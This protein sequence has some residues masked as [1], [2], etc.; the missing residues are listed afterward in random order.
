M[1]PVKYVYILRSLND[2]KQIYIGIANDLRRRL[3]QHNSGQSV[4]TAKFMPWD[5]MHYSAFVDEKK[6]HEFEKYMKSHS[7]RTFAQKR[8]Y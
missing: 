5:L 3:E 1:K 6:A 7:G 8:L 4:H 2:P